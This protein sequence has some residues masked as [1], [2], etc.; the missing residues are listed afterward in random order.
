MEVLKMEIEKIIEVKDAEE[1]DSWFDKYDKP[2]EKKNLLPIFEMKLVPGQLSRKEEIIFIDD[3][4]NGTTKF[5]KCIIF[6]IR[7]ANQDKVWFIKENQYSLLNPIAAKRKKG[8]IVGDQAIVERVG[9][10]AETRW[11]IT[12]KE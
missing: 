6:N 2:Q 9:T 7:H 1:T 4:H 3:G 5:G 12:F 10:K 11:A 8:T